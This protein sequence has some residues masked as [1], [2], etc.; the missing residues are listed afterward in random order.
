MSKQRYYEAS[1]QHRALTARF[2]WL[3]GED[4]LQKN[5][6]PT[7]GARQRG[8]GAERGQ[9]RNQ[10]HDRPRRLARRQQGWK[11]ASRG[12]ERVKSAMNETEVIRLTAI[13]YDARLEHETYRANLEVRDELFRPDFDRLCR[14]FPMFLNS[15]IGS[16]DILEIADATGRLATWIAA[17]EKLPPFENEEPTPEY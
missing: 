2:D 8:G 16:G 17:L 12:R 13:L 4:Q 6:P 3:V 7:S 5:K 9:D 10:V 14:R 15:V 11:R 1:K